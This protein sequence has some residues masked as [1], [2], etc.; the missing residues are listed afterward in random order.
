MARKTVQ[1]ISSFRYK[2]EGGAV[3]P[4]YLCK[5]TGMLAYAY[6]PSAWEGEG[7]GKAG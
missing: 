4:Q 5:C 3:D 2:H 6:D 7:M 1:W